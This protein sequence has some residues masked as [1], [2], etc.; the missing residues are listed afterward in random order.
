[1]Q[2]KILLAM[3]QT[4]PHHR[5]CKRS[6]TLMKQV[7]YSTTFI[8]IYMYNFEDYKKCANEIGGRVEPT[9]K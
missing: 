1:M 6:I 4:F 3:I 7:K 2:G 9:K 8:E 5:R